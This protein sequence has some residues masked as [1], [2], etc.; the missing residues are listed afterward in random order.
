[1]IMKKSQGIIKTKIVTMVGAHANFIQTARNK[2]KKGINGI[3][4]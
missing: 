1:M 2:P 4:L 3:D